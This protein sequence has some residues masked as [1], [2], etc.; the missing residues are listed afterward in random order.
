[1]QTKQNKLSEL[2]M[3]TMEGSRH[4]ASINTSTPSVSPLLIY[5][6]KQQFISQSVAKRF[7]S[8]INK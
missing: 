7:L 8:I 5:D 1:M 4:G 6:I 2:F 3:Y